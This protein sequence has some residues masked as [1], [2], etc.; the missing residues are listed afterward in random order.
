MSEFK[1]VG[2]ELDLFA[3][4]WNWKAYWSRQ[5]QPFIKGDV[6]EVGAGIGSNTR[7]LDP[8]GTGR[9][10]CLEPDPELNRQLVN[11]LAGKGLQRRYEAV[12][13]VL[14]SLTDQ[15]FDTIIYIDVLEHIENDVEE[16]RQAVWHL[17]PD[18]HLIILSPAHRFLFSEFDTAIGHYR[19][20]NSASLR[21]IAP[22]NLR[23]VR[24]RYLDSAG[25]IL[26]AGNRL[27]LRQAVPTKTQ[28]RLWDHWIVPISRVLDKIFLY[29]IGKTIVVVWSR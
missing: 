11:N 24:M 22:A 6:V 19:R 29:S 13:G 3:A 10:V 21:T 25:L 27:L 26:S 16:L 28:L 18:G 2:S 4:V 9:W 14:Q 17:R 8:G 12:C 23:L 5:M 7:F 15:Q 20:Y 1:Y